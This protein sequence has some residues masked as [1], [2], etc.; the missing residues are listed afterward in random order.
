MRKRVVF[1]P[2]GW[3]DLEVL[4]KNLQ[5]RILDALERYAQLGVGDVKRL[6]GRPRELPGVRPG[7]GFYAIY[8]IESRNVRW[9]QTA[10][11]AGRHA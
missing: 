1:L 2:H 11:V 6:Q 5:V 3:R 8:G 10:R 9:P 4:E 7:P